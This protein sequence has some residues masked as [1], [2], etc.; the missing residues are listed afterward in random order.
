MCGAPQLQSFSG[1]QHLQVNHL[2]SST[3]FLFFSI[4]FLM[5]FPS[6][7]VGVGFWWAK[8]RERAK[9]YAPIWWKWKWKWKC[10]YIVG[11]WEQFYAI[12]ICGLELL[13]DANSFVIMLRVVFPSLICICVY[14]RESLVIEIVTVWFGLIWILVKSK[15]KLKFITKIVTEII[16]FHFLVIKS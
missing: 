4:C 3:S 9:L 7:V 11:W 16:G 5:F 1:C 14:L 15:V 12:F 10:R 6:F 8:T 13:L 2:N